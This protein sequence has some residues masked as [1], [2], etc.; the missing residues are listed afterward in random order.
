MREQRFAV[1]ERIVE[2]LF[3]S[4]SSTSV[5]RNKLRGEKV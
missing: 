3:S 4:V 2:F 1:L 5:S